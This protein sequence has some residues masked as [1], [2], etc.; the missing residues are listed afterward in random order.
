MPKIKDTPILPPETKMRRIGRSLNEWIIEKIDQEFL[1]SQLDAQIK[2]LPGSDVKPLENLLG[3]VA[4][5]AFDG[6]LDKLKVDYDWNKRREDY[7]NENA[8]RPDWDFRLNNGLTFEIG[9]ARPFHT[10]AVM[11]KIPHKCT[12]D[13]FV[14][15]QLT[16]FRTWGKIFWKG[17]DRLIML[18]AEERSPVPHEITNSAEITKINDSDNNVLGVAVIKGFDKIADIKACKGQWFL[19]K[20]GVPPT[21]SYAGWYEPMNSLKSFNELV[22]LIS[23]PSSEEQPKKKSEQ[24]YF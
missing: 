2:S 11:G 18:N 19:G 8:V 1:L 9:A 12:S 23:K 16:S 6:L 17:K 7:W 5:Y 20:A 3:L 22:T 13:Y 24:T 10:S 21:V 14:Q 15:V 4:E